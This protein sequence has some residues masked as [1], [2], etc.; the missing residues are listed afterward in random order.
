MNT[1]P[2]EALGLPV[3]ADLSDDQVRTAWRTIAAATHPDRPD[4]G[5]PAHYAAA[6]AAYATLRTAWGRSEAYADLTSSAVPAVAREPRPAPGLLTW[7][8]TLP[9]R[10]RH[11]RP[12]WFALRLLAAAALI[13]VDFHAGA[14]AVAERAVLIGLL[15]W[16][17]ITLPRDLAPPP[18]R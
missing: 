8:R 15:T 4:G 9:A 7:A 17:V 3:R 11:G 10:V 18:G 12:A 2:F 5:N 14:G 6:S 13:A 1:N 16:L